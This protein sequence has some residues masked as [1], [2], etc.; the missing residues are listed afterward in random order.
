MGLAW[1]CGASHSLLP[2]MEPTI[3]IIM[4]GDGEDSTEEMLGAAVGPGSCPQGSAFTSHPSLHLRYDEARLPHALVVLD[5]QRK[6]KLVDGRPVDGDLHEVGQP[7]VLHAARPAALQQLPAPADLLGQDRAQRQGQGDG[8]E[9]GEVREELVHL[10]V[11]E[12]V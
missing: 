1:L 10:G 5:G 2:G 12:P 4:T 7:L 8:R 3:I 11:A 9:D 6:V